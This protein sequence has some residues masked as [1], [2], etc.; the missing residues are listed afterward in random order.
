M[1]PYCKGQK[2]FCP[3]KKPL[4]PGQGLQ[5]LWRANESPDLPLSKKDAK[6]EIASAGQAPYG[7]S[8]IPD[9]S[10]L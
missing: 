4:S 7:V 2:D 3:E 6:E 9:Q 5:P 10:F 8:V 1:N